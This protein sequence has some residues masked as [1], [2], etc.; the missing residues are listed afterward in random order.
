MVPGEG[1]PSMA[2]QGKAHTPHALGGRGRLKE[3]GF[4][5]GWR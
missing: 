1:G 5:R 4:L 2:E 3:Q